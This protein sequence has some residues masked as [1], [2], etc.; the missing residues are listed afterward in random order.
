MTGERRF[1]PEKLAKLEGER[2]RRLQPPGPLVDLVAGWSPG[3]VLDIGVGVGYYA[4]PLVQTIPDVR[5]IGL[6][7]EPRM[8]AELGDRL[9][10]L[11]D[12]AGR[13][14]PM[15]SPADSQ[16]P[17]PIDAACVDVALAVNL[18]HELD[19]RPAFLAEIGRVLAPGGHLVI[20]DWDPN[21]R[22]D[23]GPPADHRLSAQQLQAEVA[24]AGLVGGRLHGLYPDLYTL[25][26]EL[27]PA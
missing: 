1:S 11:G 19:D 6:D 23:F 13:I 8:L 4:I 15:L 26:A 5:V 9:A 17:Y 12:E 24:A 7:V 14:E 2:R 18:A 20:C 3:L 27:P 16:A 10:A 21:G 25:V 22:D